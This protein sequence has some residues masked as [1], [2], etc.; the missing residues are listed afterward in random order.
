MKNAIHVPHAFSMLFTALHWMLGG[1]VARKVSLCLSVHQ[2]RQMW[3]SGKKF[4]Q[5]FIPYERTL[6]LVFWGKEWLV[7][8]DPSTWNFGST[9]PH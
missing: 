3:Q 6:S 4:V 1:L 5:I 9:G 8:G 7:G 2:T